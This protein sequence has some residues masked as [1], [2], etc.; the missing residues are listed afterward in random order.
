MNKEQ[1]GSQGKGYIPLGPARNKAKL[2]KENSRPFIPSP[3]SKPIVIRYIDPK[4][5]PLF[6]ELGK[7]SQKV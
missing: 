4:L 2:N 5:V 7:L 6:I 3:L 1:K